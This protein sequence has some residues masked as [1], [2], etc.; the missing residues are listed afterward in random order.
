MQVG[1]KKHMRL[2]DIFVVVVMFELFSSSFVS[3]FNAV[4]MS[5]LFTLR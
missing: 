5:V 4:Y 3:C 2:V 1:K